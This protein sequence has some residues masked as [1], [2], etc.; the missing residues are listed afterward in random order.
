MEKAVD[1]QI[2][3]LNLIGLVAGIDLSIVFVI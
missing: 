2:T 3:N 1:L